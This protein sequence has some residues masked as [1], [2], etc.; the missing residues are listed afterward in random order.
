MRKTLGDKRFIEI[1]A[2]CSL[3]ECERRDVKG[4]YARA[5]KNEIADFTGISSPYEAPDSP[6]IAVD[7]EHEDLESCVETIITYLENKKIIGVS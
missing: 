3:E 5:R 1:F 4:L 6:E 7:T 2:E